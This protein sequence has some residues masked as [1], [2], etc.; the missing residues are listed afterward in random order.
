MASVWMVMESSGSWSDF[1]ESVESVWDSEAGAVSHIVR[2]IG[3]TLDEDWSRR[4]DLTW[5]LDGDGWDP[6][7]Y[8][9]EREPVLH[10]G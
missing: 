10:G 2:D 4:G 1:Y 6:I 7:S 8:T 9:V 3:A 5:V